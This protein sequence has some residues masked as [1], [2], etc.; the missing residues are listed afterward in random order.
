MFLPACYSLSFVPVYDTGKTGYR[1][2]GT[3]TAGVPWRSIIPPRLVVFGWFIILLLE[4]IGA[5]LC[6]A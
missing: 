5:K 3:I 2:S 1:L 4:V 6:E